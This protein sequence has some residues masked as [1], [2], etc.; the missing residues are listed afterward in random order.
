MT[1]FIPDH[2]DAGVSVKIVILVLSAMIHQKVLFLIDKLQNIPLARLKMWSQLDGKRRARL[3]AKTAVN[4]AG[5][6]DTKP[7][8]VA[9]AILA[10][11]GLHGDAA[12]RADRRAEI[13]G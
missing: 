5:I 9:A 3:F 13:A 7:S 1:S 6:I 11:G 10:L 8:R 4:T 12:D 2:G